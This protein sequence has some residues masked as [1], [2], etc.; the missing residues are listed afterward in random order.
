MLCS[1]WHKCVL[2]GGDLATPYVL[3]ALEVEENGNLTGLR[4]RKLMALN[5]TQ[6]FSW[7]ENN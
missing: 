7:R 6:G 5:T 4:T 1:V 3:H 2:P